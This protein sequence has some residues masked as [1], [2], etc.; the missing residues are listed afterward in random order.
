MAVA[1]SYYYELLTPAT[2]SP[3]LSLQV[4]SPHQFSFR[5]LISE[6]HTT[7]LLP[8]SRNQ[9]LRTGRR[10]GLGMRRHSSCSHGMQLCVVIIIRFCMSLEGHSQISNI[11][12]HQFLLLSISFSCLV[13]FPDPPRGRVWANDLH[14]RVAEHCIPAKVLIQL[15]KTARTLSST[16]D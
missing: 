5:H 16:C 3:N 8:W 1:H 11:I 2:H 6:S 14:F 12:I 9:T 10:K 13:W 7:Q 4:L 15:G